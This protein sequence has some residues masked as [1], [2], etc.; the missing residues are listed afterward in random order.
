MIDTHSMS[1]CYW[2]FRTCRDIGFQL[3][4]NDLL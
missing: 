4:S 1:L 2:Y 3:W